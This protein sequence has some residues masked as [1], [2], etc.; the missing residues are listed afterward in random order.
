MYRSGKVPNKLEI[1][2]QSK[3]KI[4][5]KYQDFSKLKKRENEAVTDRMIGDIKTL[6]EQQE[7]NY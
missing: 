1:Q 2:K 7:E 3:K 4:I 5:L 6:F